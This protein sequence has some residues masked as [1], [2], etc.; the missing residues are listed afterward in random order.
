VRLDL[1]VALVRQMVEE[2][3]YRGGAV[4]LDIDVLTVEEAL[5]RVCE[6]PLPNGRGSVS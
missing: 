5:A 6:A 2:Y 4:A 3:R 1:T